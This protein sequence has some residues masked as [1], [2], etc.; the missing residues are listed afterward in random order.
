MNRR[1]LAA[2]GLASLLLT[3][4]F[5]ARFLPPLRE[6]YLF[7][8]IE[9]YHYPLLNAAFRQ[10]RNG[11]FPEWDPG[12]YCGIPF[13]ANPQAA[14]FYPPHWALFA[15]NWRRAGIVFKSVEILALLHIALALWGA[16]VWIRRAGHG[17]GAAA[18]GA[19]TFAFSGFPLTQLSHPGVLAGYAW[20]PW[21]LV[22]AGAGSWRGL[23][24]ASALCLLGGYPPFWPVFALLCAL[25]AAANRGFRT[26][27]AGLALSLPLAAAQLLPLLAALGG[28]APDQSYAAGVRDAASWLALLRPETGRLA[29]LGAVGL[30][31][32]A[33]VWLGRDHRLVLL[34]LAGCAAAVWNPLAPWIEDLPVARELLRPSLFFAGF[35]VA[36][37]YGAAQ[38]AERAEHARRF[39]SLAIALVALADLYR[40]G[41]NHPAYSRPGDVD[42]I[43]FRDSR[44][45]GSS[46]TGVPDAVYREMLAH[47]EYR[48]G[49]VRSKHA[50]ELRHY[51][52]TTPQGFDPL[53]PAAYRDAVE[54][55]TAFRTNREFD[56]PLTDEFLKAFGVRWIIAAKEEAPRFDARFRRLEPEDY[57]A[58]FE[59]RAA[60]PAFAAEGGTA[61]VVAWE[62]ARRVLASASSGPAQVTFREN[63]SPG[64][65]VRVNGRPAAPQRSGP[66]FAVA[67]PPGEHV[68]EACYQAPGLRSGAALTGLA[69]L[70]LLAAPYVRARCTK[71]DAPLAD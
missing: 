28:K 29:Y 70:S 38:F 15:A 41:A 45:K 2:A 9:G 7:S 26:A 27:A 33:L 8:D 35:S 31:G 23:A 13:A 51:S 25:H 44:A 24:A 37:A 4:L 22:A 32:L 52:L 18:A 20:L 47:P 46:L 19:L 57:F 17:R 55:H 62:P 54:R 61:R 63:F 43:F 67:L 50:V 3:A 5:F 56:L 65:E 40:A 1:E 68:V 16:F 58:V 42:R 64:W 59:F 11:A 34:L 66:F 48:V 21:G 71:A 69:L 60:E 10:L 30:A 14:L 12:I 6:R 36:A 49:V 53:L 39:A